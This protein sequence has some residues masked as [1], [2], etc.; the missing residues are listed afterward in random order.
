M[1]AIPPGIRDSK[2]MVNFRAT[3]GH[4]AQ[5]SSIVNCAH[6]KSARQHFR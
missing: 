2:K 4:I 1:T 3:P 5:F 6:Y